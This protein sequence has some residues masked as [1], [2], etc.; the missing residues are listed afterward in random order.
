M[1][2][3]STFA[4]D[5]VFGVDE[6]MA[7]GVLEI[8]PEGEKPLKPTKDNNYVFVVLEGAVDVQIHR[9]YF[10]LAPSGTFAVPKGNTYAIRNVSR[11]TARIFFAQARQP[12]GAQRTAVATVNGVSV[13]SA[14]TA[15]ET[16]GD[17][18]TAPSSSRAKNGK[19]PHTNGVT[20]NRNGNG[21]GNGNADA[22]VS[23]DSSSSSI[24]PA[25]RPRG[26]PKKKQKTS[27]G[28]A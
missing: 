16:I 13:P 20:V 27:L 7:A 4:F 11:R 18:S 14:G 9:T 2:A 26:R 23:A 5:K 12:H 10:R 3:N 17:T 28:S 24:T 22:S 15:D 25:K 21:N 6:Y 8:P 19:Q 1:A